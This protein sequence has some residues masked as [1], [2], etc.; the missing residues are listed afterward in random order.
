MCLWYLFRG[1]LFRIKDVKKIANDKKIKA[2]VLIGISLICLEWALYYYSGIY[3]NNLRN[4]I[5]SLTFTITI[6]VAVIF[7][8]AS[9]K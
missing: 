3:G 6:G 9:K 7:E 1:A 5:I 2:A 4:L 8:L